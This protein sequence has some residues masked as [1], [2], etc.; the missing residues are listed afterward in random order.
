MASV[1]TD[2]S[3]TLASWGFRI[4]V[5][6]DELIVKRD[7]TAYDPRRRR[8]RAL[9]LSF[10]IALTCVLLVESF[11]LMWRG[12]TGAWDLAFTFFWAA[13]PLIWALRVL[14]PMVI[15][16]QCTGESIRL[17]HMRWGKAKLT[18]SFAKEDIRRIQY[19][20]AEPLF[21]PASLGFIAKGKKITCLTGLKCIEAQRILD[22][23][24]RMGFDVVRNPAMPVMIQME[25]SF[26]KG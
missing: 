8:K 15:D 5:K 25:Q 23:L 20:A 21:S 16:L 26:R 3:E 10:G 18:R 2:T 13:C 14:Y 12:T 6:P 22:E 9:I 24:Q 4:T 17:T 19:I 11:A 7:V 1:E